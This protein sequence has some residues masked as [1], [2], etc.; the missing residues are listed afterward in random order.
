LETIVANP[1]WQ[2]GFPT[3]FQLVRLVGCGLKQTRSLPDSLPDDSGGS[4]NLEQEGGQ[5]SAIRE[6]DPID[7]STGRSIIWFSENWLI[8]L[9]TQSTTIFHHHRYMCRSNN[10]KHHIILITLH[11]PTS[12]Q[13]KGRSAVVDSLVPT[14]R[15]RPSLSTSS[16]F[17]RSVLSRLLYT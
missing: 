6:M 12:L 13:T 4:R 8:S 15:R 2:A 10:K 1:G 16:N 17:R 14:I 3:S 7:Q 9:C 5:P 11:G